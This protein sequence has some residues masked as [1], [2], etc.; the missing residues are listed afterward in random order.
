MAWGWN[1]G[2]GYN[3][4]K[5]FARRRIPGESM[6]SSS[7]ETVG[8]RVA[9]L[10][11]LFGLVMLLSLTNVLS[12]RKGRLFVRH[13]LIGGWIGVA[14]YGLFLA[15]GAFSFIS[16]SMKNI[17]P[18]QSALACSSPIDQ[19][20]DK[21]SAIVPI[22]TDTGIGSGVLID[23]SGTV[24]T[25][26]HV[27][28]GANDIYAN[29]ASGRVKM[30]IIDTASQYDLALLKLTKFDNQRSFL[31]SSNYDVGDDVLAYGYPYNALTAGAPSITRGIISR[32]IPVADLRMTQPDSPDG[33]EL[34]Q[35]DAA[36]NPGNSGGALIG[37]CGLVGI[38]VSVSDSAQMSEYVGAVSEQGISYVVS[39]KTA[40]QAFNLHIEHQ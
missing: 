33:L 8:A 11:G 21:G 2:S 9:I 29:Y 34:V 7:D 23:G 1:S 25:A 20:R 38:V 30:T 27:I 15:G 3:T 5:F 37:R 36:V 4:C 22:G 6:G 10:F 18:E 16:I 17:E 32:V 28:D 13:I 12:K 39:S 24:L 35:T 14:I 40:A 19:Y 31:L 26:Y